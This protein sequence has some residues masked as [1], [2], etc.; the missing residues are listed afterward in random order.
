MNQESLSESMNSAN[1]GRQTPLFFGPLFE[2]WPSSWAKNQ[3]VDYQYDCE[4]DDAEQ[5]ADQQHYE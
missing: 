2:Y 1:V 4:R 3:M 5:E